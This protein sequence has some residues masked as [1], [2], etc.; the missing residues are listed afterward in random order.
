[1]PPISESDLNFKEL[2]KSFERLSGE[3]YDS[4]FELEKRAFGTQVPS[5][6]LAFF[7]G[8]RRRLAG[9]LCLLV[10]K[11]SLVGLGQVRIAENEQI[12]L[13]VTE[14]RWAMDIELHDKKNSFFQK[15]IFEKNLSGVSFDEVI[16]SIFYTYRVTETD[17][18][19]TSLRSALERVA[20]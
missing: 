14:D 8:G 9:D 20:Q 10:T 11:T 17:F 5:V 1:M 15:I 6:W 19:E 12:G 13:I 18:S 4:Y 2:L 16:S 3:S 7:P